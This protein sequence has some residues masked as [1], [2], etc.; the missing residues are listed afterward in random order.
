ML[1]HL[2]RL[3]HSLLSYSVSHLDT[4]LPINANYKLMSWITYEN[5]LG[6]QLI[7]EDL[8]LRLAQRVLTPEELADV[9]QLKVREV[10]CER[11]VTYLRNWCHICDVRFFIF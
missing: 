10:H 9:G 4:G 2:D 1:T 11:L 6:Y 7:A 3:T 5:I 8:L